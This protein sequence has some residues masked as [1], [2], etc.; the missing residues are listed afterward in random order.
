M[1]VLTSN[2]PFVA[3]VADFSRVI[4]ACRDDPELR[5][6]WQNW[7]LEDAEDREQLADF[8]RLVKH[9]SERIQATHEIAGQCEVCSQS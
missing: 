7:L 9:A 3:P 4:G 1:I 8:F 2:D 6:A 5:T